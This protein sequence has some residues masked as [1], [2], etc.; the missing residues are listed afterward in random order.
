MGTLGELMGC[1][2]GAWGDGDSE[3]DKANG[4][5]KRLGERWAIP[6]AHL[7]FDHYP[8]SF[9]SESYLAQETVPQKAFAAKIYCH[10]DEVR[11]QRQSLDW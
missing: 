11:G 2:E 3:H 10:W 5:A 4:I 7:G 1:S 6:N 8:R 9:S